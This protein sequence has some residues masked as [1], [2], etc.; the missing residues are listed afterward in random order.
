MKQLYLD[1]YLFIVIYCN[2]NLVGAHNL[3]LLARARGTRTLARTV[4]ANDWNDLQFFYFDNNNI[5]CLYVM[6]P[7]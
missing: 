2:Y 4:H 7:M 1:L 6:I 5:L 3:K